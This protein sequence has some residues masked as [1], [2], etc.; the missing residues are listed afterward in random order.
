MLIILHPELILSI[1]LLVYM[2]LTESVQIQIHFPNS[3]L[4][5]ATDDYTTDLR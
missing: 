2:Y 4:I 5:H 3:S 1:I